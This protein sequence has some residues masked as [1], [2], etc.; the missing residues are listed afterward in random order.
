MWQ[1]WWLRPFL[2]DSSSMF[3]FLFVSLQL[4]ILPVR[5]LFEKNETKQIIICDNPM[6]YSQCS[7]Q[8]PIF[9]G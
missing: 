7:G 1:S 4:I 2:A 6:E 5:Y 3:E 9:D 8:I